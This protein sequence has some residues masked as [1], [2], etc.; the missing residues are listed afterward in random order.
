MLKF[1]MDDRS[2]LECFVF[3][4]L[5]CLAT[6]TVKQTT[7][8]AATSSTAI[9]EATTSIVGTTAAGNNTNLDRERVN[10]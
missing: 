10:Q 9:G 3:A 5:G 6:T 2:I 8:P 7:S 4:Q 1:C